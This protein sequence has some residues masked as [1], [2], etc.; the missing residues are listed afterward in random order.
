MPIDTLYMTLYMIIVI[1]V[2]SVTIYEM[3]AIKMCMTWTLTFR[4]EQSKMLICKSKAR[5]IM[6]SYLMLIAM[7][8]L[9]LITWEIFR[10]SNKMPNENEGQ[11]QGQGRKNV[12]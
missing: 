11:G 6:T 1:C 12:T 5:I 4:M 9:S 2:L 7:F 3:F 10:K 8:V